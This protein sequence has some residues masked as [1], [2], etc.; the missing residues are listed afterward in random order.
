MFKNQHEQNFTSLN[1][2]PNGNTDDPGHSDAF[3]TNNLG[4]STLNTNH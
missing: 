1:K 2:D 3:P 4:N